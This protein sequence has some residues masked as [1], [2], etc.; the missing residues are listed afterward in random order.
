MFEEIVK[1]IFTPIAIIF[2]FVYFFQKI[3]EKNLSKDIEKYKNR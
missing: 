1:L 3:F 2:V